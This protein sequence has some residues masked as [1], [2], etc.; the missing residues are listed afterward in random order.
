MPFLQKNISFGPN[1]F[2]YTKERGARDALLHLVLVWITALT[3]KQKV[4]VYCSDVSGAFD[5]VRVKRLVEKL[6]A[7]KLH[8]GI[9]NV[10]TS[11]LR[12]RTAHV[13]V[14]GAKSVEILLRNMVFQGTVWGPTLWNVFYEDA[15]RAV[16][17]C[18]FNEIVYADDLNAYRTIPS[19]KTNDKIQESMRLCQTELHTWGRANEV[20]FDPAKESMHILSKEAPLGTAFKILGVDF[21]CKLEMENAITEV[22]TQA[23]W[24]LRMLVRTKRFYSDSDLVL[25]YKA[26]LLSYLEYRTPAVYH[27][28]REFLV[29][30]DKSANSFL[31]HSGS[32]GACRPHRIQFGSI[33]SAERHGN[34]RSHTPDNTRKGPWAFQGALPARYRL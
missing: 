9:V 28:K 19:T 15:R 12:E 31:G 1:Q 10:L 7:T 32:D 29:R 33:V 20:V 18:F 11:W 5:R 24:K 23:G 8:P 2:A 26:H 3:R 30:L 14:G 21:D 13:V 16:Q 27:A 34:A 25:L 22:V 17:E 4:A 6:K